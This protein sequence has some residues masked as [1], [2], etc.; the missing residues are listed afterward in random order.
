[1]NEGAPRP[2]APP[3]EAVTGDP[4]HHLYARALKFFPPPS[5]LGN[6]VGGVRGALFLRADEPRWSTTPG[7]LVL[8]ALV[9]LI[10]N[11]M[12]SLILVG[13]EGI[14][15]YAA[16]PSF[17]FHL[18]LM[19]LFGYLAGRITSRPT[20]VTAV[21]VALIAISIPIE[22][23]FGVLEWGAVHLPRLRFL[24][25]YLHAPNYYRF[26]WWWSA[27]SLVLLFRQR[28]GLSR[29]LAVIGTFA[30][31]LVTP[32]WFYPRSDLWL[33]PMEGGESGELKVTE[34]VLSAQAGLLDDRLAEL[35]PGT[36]KTPSLYFVG[37]AGDA[38]EDVFLKEVL[39]GERL[40]VDRFGTS[41]R[42]V[43]LA[44]NPE[45][46]TT[47]PFA[48]ATNLNRA[49]KGVGKAMNREDDVLFL[50]LT[51]HG[52]RE[53]ELAVNNGP[54]ELDQL[55]PEALRRMLQSSR[56]NWK[57]LVVSSCFS[58]GFIEPLKDDHTLI[59]T[60]ADATHE[61]FGCGF[62]EKFTWFGEAFFGALGQNRSFTKAFASARETIHRWEE[63]QGE[64]PSNPQ[65]WEGK[66]IGEKL[67]AVEEALDQEPAQKR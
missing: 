51:S 8:I 11:L 16:L 60:A 24:E 39:A 53:H 41:G 43:A 23:T 64:T 4:G 9:D 65:I 22:L 37:F 33:S 29:R 46:A 7:D 32:L 38:T 1:M 34:D 31:L 13:R 49:L 15:N 5:L 59:I 56:I 66:A 30:A 17:F 10:G 44:N 6:L 14:F 55:T 61:S 54:L 58:G 42:T 19:L 3:H 48:T 35:K 27:A 21:P 36:K 2:Q 67:K 62:G 28:G 18:P 45:S 26:F 40:F 57:V 47:L 20:M 50:Y 63:D 25:D 12:S 52:S